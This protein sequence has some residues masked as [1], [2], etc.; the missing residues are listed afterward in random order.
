[1]FMS[2]IWEAIG[3]TSKYDRKSII[4]RFI[5]FDL[6]CWLFLVYGLSLFFTGKLG[7]EE[8]MNQVYKLVENFLD[9]SQIDAHFDLWDDCIIHLLD[10]DVITT[11]EAEEAYNDKY[12]NRLL[13]ELKIECDCYVEQVTYVSHITEEQR[14]YRKDVLNC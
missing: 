10:N 6:W 3:G 2:W 14:N 8:I 9:V 12:L 5:A 11:E 7:Q 1:M 4:K 13:E